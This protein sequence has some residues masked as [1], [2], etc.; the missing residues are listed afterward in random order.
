MGIAPSS[1]NAE[2]ESGL[3]D[4][5]IGESYIKVQVVADNM[6]AVV[7]ISDNIDELL[8]VSESVEAV[9]TAKVAAETAA[10]NAVV[11]A[12]TAEAAKNALLANTGAGIVGVNDGS[13]GSVFSTVQGFVNKLFSSTGST[14]IGF[15]QSGTGAVARWIQDKL[16]ETI[17]IKDF[18]AIGDVATD[19]TAAVLL[20]IDYAESLGG[21]EIFVPRGTYTISAEL[22]VLGSNIRFRGCGTVASTFRFTH[23]TA[24]GIVF[25]DGVTTQYRNWVTDLGLITS[26]AKSAGA[27][28]RFRNV[29]QGGVTRFYS[30]TQF[31]TIAVE[32]NSVLINIENGYIVNPTA[33]TGKGILIAGGNDTNVRDVLVAGDIG[34]QPLCAVQITKTS[35]VWLD[36]VGGLWC[37]IPLLIQPQGTDI[38]EHLFTSRCAWDSSSGHGVL[39]QPAIGAT[40]R[41]WTSTS[42]WAAT[43]ALSGIAIAGSGTVQGIRLNGFRAFNNGEHGL[44]A[45]IGDDIHINGGIYGGNGGASTNT[46]DGIKIDTS[47]KF[48]I[49]SIQAGPTEGS[50]AHQ[51]YGIE[52]T[53]AAAD[54]FL[55]IGNDLRGNSTGGLSNAA[56]HNRTSKIVEN[57]LGYVTDI[58]TETVLGRVTAGAGVIEELSKTQ[59]TTLVNSFTNTLKGVVPASGGGTVNFLRADGTWAAPPS[60]TTIVGITGTLAEFNAALTGADF[61]TGGGTATGINTGDQTITLTGDVTGSGTGSFAATLATVN[62]NTGTYGGVATVPQISVNGKGLITGVT[63]VGIEAPWAGISG[64]PAAIT[65]LSGTNTGDESKAS[66]DTKIG[67]DGSNTTT[68]YRKDGTWAA[69]PGGGSGLDNPQTG[70]DLMRIEN[71]GGTAPAGSSGPGLEIVGNSSGNVVVQAYNRTNGLFIPVFWTGLEQYFSIGGVIRMQLVAGG[72]Y[73]PYVATPSLPPADYLNFVPQRLNASGGRVIPR[74]R[75]E[76]GTYFTPA[77]HPGRNSIASGQANGN[78]STAITFN[79]MAALT[80]V[81]TATAR[82]VASTSRL[83]RARRLGYVSAA[84]AG[85]VG[86]LHNGTGNT[87]WTVGGASG[88]GFKQIIRFAVSDASLVSGA[89][90]IIGMRNA[91]AAPTAATNPNTLTNIIALAQM[92][93]S[94]NWHIIYGGS[95]AQTPVDTGIAINNTDLLEL[96]IYARPDVNNKVTWRLENITTG[97]VASGE[98]TGT[99]G[100]ALPANTTFLGPVIWRSN[101]A[102]AAAVGIDIAGVYIESDFG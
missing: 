69:P 12:N 68:F 65:A 74:W 26:G 40:V 88:G 60:Q 84:T 36:N 27:A 61:V 35:A 70:T 46:F 57:N 98:L 87:Q 67:A 15:I 54:N 72:T 96:I 71:T 100:T 97:V 83:T 48:S 82:N 102:T 32:G 19:D 22:P 79:G 42:D 24:D 14:V 18:G 93:G 8:A 10:T 37:G 31:C 5:Q 13:G 45:Q 77:I 3:I 53:N 21:A 94:A 4:D 85:A 80:A 51:K 16:R 101:N 56:G 62:S 33:A 11:S 6:D 43:N 1:I 95:A 50:S 99:A 38:V 9:A 78:A 49:Q 47:G 92:N 25:G 7:N 75:S 2:S 64:K 30:S 44:H 86:G 28:V 23:P 91:T 39:I 73:F 20:A 89:H 41:R 58:P 34:A 81:G 66:I 76:D 55:I 59:L 90:A 52:I 17:S 29:A 63:A